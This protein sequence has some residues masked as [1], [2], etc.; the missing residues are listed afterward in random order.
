MNYYLIVL[1]LS[2]QAEEVTIKR[3]VQFQ[4]QGESRSHSH[5]SDLESEPDA[6]NSSSLEPDSHQLPQLDLDVTFEP[7]SAVRC[8]LATCVHC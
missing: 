7:T 5:S 6:V 3:L 8:E 2:F 1:S 4:T